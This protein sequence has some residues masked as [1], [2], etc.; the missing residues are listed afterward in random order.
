VRE[1]GDSDFLSIFKRHRGCPILAFGW[2]SGSPLR[3]KR[4]GNRAALAAE[5]PHFTGMD[6]KTI[7]VRPEVGVLSLAV[8]FSGDFP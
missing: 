2:R 8:D 6:Q 7:N 3:F 4:S 1:G 5:V